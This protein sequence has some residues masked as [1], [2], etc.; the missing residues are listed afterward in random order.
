MR[1]RECVVPLLGNSYQAAALLGTHI[2]TPTH[3]RTRNVY[4][5]ASGNVQFYEYI[6]YSHQCSFIFSV[7]IFSSAYYGLLAQ[8][9]QVLL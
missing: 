4:L 9:V 2:N 3:I 6:L 5:A 7:C 1:S 8:C